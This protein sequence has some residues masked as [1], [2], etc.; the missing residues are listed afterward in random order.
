MSAIWTTVE[1]GGKLA[2]KRDIWCCLGQGKI[3]IFFQAIFG[4]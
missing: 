3:N 2:R 1:C 4:N